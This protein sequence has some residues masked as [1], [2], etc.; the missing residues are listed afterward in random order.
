MQLIAL[1][2]CFSIAFEVE[3]NAR[4]ILIDLGDKTNEEI[5]GIIFL[6]TFR[7]L[8]VDFRPFLLQENQCLE[9][10]CLKYQ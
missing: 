4:Y 1:V 7:F 6:I 2:V 8:F 10:G 3:S 5:S 9:E